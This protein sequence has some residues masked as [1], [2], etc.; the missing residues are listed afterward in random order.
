MPAV[1]PRLLA[2]ARAM[3]AGTVAIEAAIAVV[4]LL[5]LGW[6]IARMRDALLLVFCATTYALAPVAGFG[7]LLLSIGVAQL[8]PARRRTR[9]TYLVAFALVLVEARWPLF[10]ELVDRIR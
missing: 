7:W 3:A 2:V 6:R 8:E 9:A 4:F 5:P 1:P 10:S